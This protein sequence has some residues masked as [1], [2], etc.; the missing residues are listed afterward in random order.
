MDEQSW[1][2]V[3]WL[4]LVS[5]QIK[6]EHVKDAPRSDQPEVIDDKKEKKVL[7]IVRAMHES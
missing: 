7:D 4:G 1:D 5:K 2:G 3:S 6:A